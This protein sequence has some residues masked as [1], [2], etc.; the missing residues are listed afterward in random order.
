MRT[1]IAIVPFR[2][3]AP[4][5]ARLI[6]MD[7]VPL[8]SVLEPVADVAADDFRDAVVSAALDYEGETVAGVLFADRWGGGGVM[9]T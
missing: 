7:A 9:L 4:E 3:G 6:D 8:A 5:A 1:M 2:E